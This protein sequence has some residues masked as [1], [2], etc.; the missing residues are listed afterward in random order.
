MELINDSTPRP[1]IKFL[2]KKKSIFRKQF[3]TKQIMTNCLN[4]ENVSLKLSILTDENRYQKDFTKLCDSN[5][6]I[7]MF[8]SSTGNILD[9]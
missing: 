5:N 3:H 4:E 8:S 2:M 7:V 9:R 1:K 6:I